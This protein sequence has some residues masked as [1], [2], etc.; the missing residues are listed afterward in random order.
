VETR[1]PPACN[2]IE[3]LAWRGLSL[4][5]KS[6]TFSKMRNCIENLFK[7]NIEP[8]NGVRLIEIERLQDN[9]TNSSIDYQ[10]KY[11][12]RIIG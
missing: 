11:K 7:Y 1:P 6:F 10:I 2:K 12:K 5:E 9:F 3:S 4:I 8:K